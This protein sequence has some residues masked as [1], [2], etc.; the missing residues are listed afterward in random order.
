MQTSVPESGEKLST[1][2]GLRGF[3]AGCDFSPD[4][5]QLLLGGRNGKIRIWDFERNLLSE[6]DTG[7]DEDVTGVR[8]VGVTNL[9]AA[10]NRDGCAKTWNFKTRQLIREFEP[11]GL[12]IASANLSRRGDLAIGHVN[13]S[14]TLWNAESGL[15]HTN[16][17]AHWRPWS[18]SPSLPMAALWQPAEKKAWRSCGIWPHNVRS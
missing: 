11:S 8:T 5:R 2:T 12:G 7:G 6:F 10:F 17:P 18:V 13:G 1:L 4:G 14:V 16:F 15:M 9:V 3:Q